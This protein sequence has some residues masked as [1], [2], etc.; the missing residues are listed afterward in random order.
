[1]KR[2]PQLCRGG[3]SLLAVFF[4]ALFAVLA[5][6]FAAM[7]NMNVQM[8]RN[9]RDVSAAQAAAESGLEYANYLVASYVPPTA[10]YNPRNTVTESEAR[11][12]LGYFANHVQTV[13][14]GSPLLG[15]HGIYYDGVAGELRVPATGTMSLA[16]GANGGFSLHLRFEAGLA[17]APHHVI[18]TS[19][20]ALGAVQRTVGL[21]FPIKKDGQ[22]LEYAV[23]SRGRMWIVGDSTIHGG[24][25]SSWNRPEIS[26]FKLAAASTVEGTINTV[27][28]RQAIEAEGYQLETLDENGNP[29][30]DENGERVVGANDMIQGE[31]EGINY[32]APSQNMPG[33]SIND[34]DTSMYKSQVTSLPSS[35]VRRTEYFPH[36][37]GDYTRPRDSGSR[38]LSR[39][40]YENQTYNN[41]ALPANRNAL[42]K[43][44]TFEGVL[45]VDCATSGSTYYNNVRFE[46]CTFHGTIVSNV[47]QVFKWMHN[48]LYFTGSATFENRATA[49]ATILAP[50]LNVN[51]GNCNPAAGENNVLRGA[52]VGG[53]VDVRGNAE[54]FGTIISMCDT[55]QWSS[56]YVTN[57]GAT[58]EDGG[59]E[60]VEPGDIG[61]IHITPDPANML[62]S[63]IKT[64]IVLA[65][66]GNSYVE[67]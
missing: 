12:T 8:S 61:T 56:G 5:V 37:A 58:T 21:T 29:I 32:E 20:G 45:Y 50:H 33:M 44:C 14:A 6:S 22:V 64:P 57:I 10:A 31:H 60:T 19:T 39:Y 55:S 54:V 47:P 49:E 48:C 46:N 38:Q 36:A 18:V 41:A 24:I 51:L 59:S 16:S 25:Y 65:R 15:G 66:D 4:V 53:I 26:P 52:I 43:N 2:H 62:P 34:Y 13:L 7:S 30:Y 42:F 67:Y 11:T 3:A 27:L 23:A 63:G 28:S 35:S 9:H 40:V 1:M 17:P